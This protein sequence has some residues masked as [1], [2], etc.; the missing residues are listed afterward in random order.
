MR[1]S[2]ES[3]ELGIHCFVGVVVVID[4]GRWIDLPHI[5][6]GGIKPAGVENGQTNLALYVEEGPSTNELLYQVHVT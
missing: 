2:K 5:K 1:I 6:N 4:S 3:F